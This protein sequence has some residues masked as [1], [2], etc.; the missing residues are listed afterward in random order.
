M[1]A[2]GLEKH[3]TVNLKENDNIRDTYM[4]KLGVQ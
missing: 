2:Q 4:S 3:Q 1:V